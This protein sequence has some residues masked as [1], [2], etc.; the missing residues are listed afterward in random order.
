[1]DVAGNVKDIILDPHIRRGLL[2][3]DCKLC[4]PPVDQN[5]Q[6]DLLEEEMQKLQLLIE[7][8]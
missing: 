8:L 3:T 2:P 5:P 7:E 6:K 4:Y 1:M